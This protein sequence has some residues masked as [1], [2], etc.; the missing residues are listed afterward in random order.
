MEDSHRCGRNLTVHPVDP[1]PIHS[2]TYHCAVRLSHA[3]VASPVSRRESDSLSGLAA[4]S[5]EGNRR[6]V[7][8]N[9]RDLYGG[10]LRGILED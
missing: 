7:A 4:T 9:D 3:K 6:D 2:K 8:E 1:R 10:I 5:G